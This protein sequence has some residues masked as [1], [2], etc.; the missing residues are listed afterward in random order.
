MIKNKVCIIGAGMVGSATMI[1]IL[2]TGLVAE[3]VMIDKNEK[4]AE[5]EAM[6]AFHT[7]SFTY[8]PNVRIR[9]GTYADCKDAQIIVMTAGPS[10]KPGEKTDRR[11]LTKINAK[12]TR[13]VME[14]ITAYTK[15]SLFLSLIQ[16]IL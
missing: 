16:S 2:N 15:Q 12:V 3:I 1:A 13:S 5:G 14:K 6:D 9:K 4:K 8:M 10:I 11:A 7:T